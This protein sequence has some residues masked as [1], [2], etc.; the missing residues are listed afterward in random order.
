MRTGLEGI[1]AA[2]LLV[3]FLP[4]IA[5]DHIALYL[6]GLPVTNMLGG[7]LLDMLGVALLASGFLLAIEYLP[8]APERILGTLFAGVMLWRIADLAIQLSG[9]LQIEHFWQEHLRKQSCVAILLL[10]GTL[11][12][13]LP[14]IAQP[15]V[16]TVRLGIAGLAFSALWI[17][18]QLLYF[19][20]ARPPA[21][22]TTALHPFTPA[23]NA[24]SRRIVWILFDELSYDQ[25]F[26]RQVTGMKLPNFGR[27]RTE[28]VSFSGLRPTGFHT[29]LIIPSL[30]LGRHIEHIRSTVAGD[31]W[32]KEEDRSRWLA[33]DPNAT[34]F[35]FAQR[36]GWS[37][38]VDGWYN[39]YCHILASVLSTCSWEPLPGLPMEP[40]G[41]A[42]QKS[43]LANAAILPNALLEK[44]TSLRTAPADAHMGDIHIAE[45]RNVMARTHALIENQQVSFVF[46][47][48][49]VPHPPGIYDRQLHLLRPGGTYLD[50][51]VLADDTLGALLKE[52]DATPAASRTTVIV[53][54]DHSWRTS[55]W[56]FFPGWSAEEERASGGRFDDRPVLL[57]HFPG[58][59]SGMDVN[60][61]LSV[62][63]EHDMIAEMLRGK[64]NNSEDLAAFLASQGH[65]AQA[66]VH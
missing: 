39:P 29:A 44:L 17:V 42:E 14:R 2:L 61:V 3:P 11:A 20:L 53:S 49:P 10:S 36:N 26:D 58:Q 15:A 51:L 7:V 33:F 50:N 34:L 19:A 64:M 35:G 59:R 21:E 41:A 62:L 56:R 24:S 12:W 13:I 22:R 45:Y 40:S 60:S 9:M 38:G 32:Y 25:T 52:I 28:S 31:L 48:L 30:F 65:S 55:L 57:V 4:Y 23:V 47:H 66:E 37:T 6:H 16:R 5:P 1:G 54:S 8:K 43:A 18:P 27:L 46:L 63:L